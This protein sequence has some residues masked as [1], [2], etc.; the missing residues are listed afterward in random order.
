MAERLA[1]PTAHELDALTAR[2]KGLGRELVEHVT[3]HCGVRRVDVNEQNTQAAGFYARMGF[4]I[5]SRD[6]L[7][8]S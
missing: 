1:S 8:P 4:R 2:G 3:T 6:T 7:D 5:V